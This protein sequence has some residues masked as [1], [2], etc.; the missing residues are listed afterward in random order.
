MRPNGLRPR[1]DASNPPLGPPPTVRGTVLLVLIIAGLPVAASYPIPS[2]SLVTGI[3]AVRFG[4]RPLARRIR[5]RTIDSGL[6]PVCVPGTEVCL[7]A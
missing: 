7:G 4:V 3:L 2:A 6:G 1:D 5:E